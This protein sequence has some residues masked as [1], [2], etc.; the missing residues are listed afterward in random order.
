[1]LA[2]S[3]LLKLKRIVL[4]SSSKFSHLPVGTVIRLIKEKGMSG[5]L[6]NLYE[7]V[8]NL[9]EPYIQSNKCKDILLKPK[10]S[11]GISTFPFLLLN[12]NV[13]TREK[14][15]YGCSNSNSH[16][17][18]SDDPNARCTSCE[19]SMSRKLKYVAQPVANGAVAATGGFVTYMV[20][21]DLVVNPMST[22]SCIALLNKFNV[23]DVGVREEE[24]VSFG[25]EEVVNYHY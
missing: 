1:M 15:F 14:T 22:V 17:T 12:D 9:K 20:T 10:S 4:I 2:K 8:E 6:P 18:V 3:Y 19:Y 24:V 21:D 11:V 23:R 5:S 25:M 7:S 13:P 16:S